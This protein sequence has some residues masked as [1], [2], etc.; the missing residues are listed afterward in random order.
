MD[1]EDMVAMVD[2]VDMVDMDMGI[3]MYIEMEMGMDMDMYK[4]GFQLE[5][6]SISWV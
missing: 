1:V 6:V 3:V 2:M 5:F 4:G